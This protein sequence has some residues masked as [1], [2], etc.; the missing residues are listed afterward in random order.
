MSRT[1][2]SLPRLR[3]TQIGL[4]NWPLVDQIKSD[5]RAG[6][7]AFDE[8]RGQIGGVRDR[9]GT[10]YVIEGHHRMAAA[11]ELFHE[12]GDTAP[13]WE[14]LRW[15]RWTELDKPPSDRRPLPARPW[16]GAFRNWIGF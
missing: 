5:M 13:V 11:L 4:R 12:T 15:G 9:R 10:Y 16:W 14:L 7:Y 1:H 6:R 2:T 3:G 8:R